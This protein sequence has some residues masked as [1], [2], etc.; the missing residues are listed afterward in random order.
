MYGDFSN[1]FDDISKAA[2]DF[3]REFSRYTQDRYNYG[4]QGGG[5]EN[6]D[7]PPA[8]IY[9]AGGSIVFEFALAGFAE[10]DISLVFQGDYM[11]LSAVCKNTL[12]NCGTQEDMPDDRQYSKRSLRMDPVE[13]QKYYVPADKYA[14]EKTKAVYKNGLLRVSIP[15]KDE[16]DF[17]GCV[18][19]SIES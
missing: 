11:L 14:Q 8:N 13:R 9:T 12:K 1:L 18:K 7:W 4:N 19:V 15:A 5:G 17:A 16:D 3:Q 2:K 6:S 10:N